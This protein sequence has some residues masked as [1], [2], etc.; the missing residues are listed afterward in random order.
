MRKRQSAPRADRAENDLV[1]KS[2]SFLASAGKLEEVRTVV[3]PDL[4]PNEDTV[5]RVC[6]KLSPHWRQGA[7]IG[8][9]LIRFRPLGV[10][11]NYRSVAVRTCGRWTRS[12]DCAGRRVPSGPRRLASVSHRGFD[13][14]HCL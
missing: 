12:P 4:L 2:L 7:R 1:L 5:R 13:L 10:R 3:V 6:E 8:Y 11:A 9:K 14:G